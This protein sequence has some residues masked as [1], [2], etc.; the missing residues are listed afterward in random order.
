[1]KIKTVSAFEIARLVDLEPSGFCV[2]LLPE[3]EPGFLSELTKELEVQANLSLIVVNGSGSGVEALLRSLRNSHEAVAV[4]LGLEHWSDSDF[5]DLDINRSR[6]TTS[7]FLI[8]AGTSTVAARLLNKA[9]NI[10][11][12]VGANIFLWIPDHSCPTWIQA[13]W[14]GWSV[15]NEG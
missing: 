6:L 5:G 3:G 10:R 8:F 9:P 14:A 13:T 11:S 1:M 2:L 15:L 4:V 12:F 7:Q